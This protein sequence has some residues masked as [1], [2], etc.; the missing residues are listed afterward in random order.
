ML[1][2]FH[3][4]AWAYIVCTHTQT[5]IFNSMPFLIFS[6]LSNRN[7]GYLLPRYSGSRHNS[8]SPSIYCCVECC[9]F[10]FLYIPVVGSVLKVLLFKHPNGSSKVRVSDVLYNYIVIIIFIFLLF[11]GMGWVTCVNYFTS[12]LVNFFTPSS[13]S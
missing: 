8:E 11:Q 1:L 10:S 5:L 4:C 3:V 2:W 6:I 9:S 13:D 7:I 12:L